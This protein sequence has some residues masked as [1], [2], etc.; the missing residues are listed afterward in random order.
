MGRRSAHPW[1]IPL[2]A[3]LVFN[4]ANYSSWNHRLIKPLSTGTDLV[5]LTIGFPY[6]LLSATAPLTQALSPEAHGHS[7]YRLFA[8][9]NLGSIIGLLA[10]PFWVEA[11]FG[12]RQQSALWFGAFLLFAM[13][14]T[15]TM[16]MH[17]SDASQAHV[18]WS[19]ALRDRLG[20]LGLSALVSHS[21]WRSRTRLPLTQ[22]V[23]PV[24]GSCRY[25]RIYSFVICTGDRLGNEN[26]L[27]SRD[28]DRCSCD[29]LAALSGWQVPWWL[30]LGLWC[31]VLFGGCML[32]HGGW[33]AA[34]LLHHS[35]T[36]SI[37]RSAVRCRESVSGFSHQPG[38]LCA[39]KFT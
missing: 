33:F 13:L 24:T 27:V 28:D 35:G 26:G 9:S 11:E 30:Q 34:G 38:Y 31:L 39:L 32:F 15:L 3:W 14:M 18:D 4:L 1:H 10:Y 16:I 12:L 17:R 2:L 6:V 5:S 37:F 8:W 20:W 29:D 21:S 25:L 36:I 7:P 23:T 22:A 19:P